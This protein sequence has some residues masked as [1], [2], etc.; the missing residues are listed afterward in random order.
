M[1]GADGEGIR[2]EGSGARGRAACVGEGKVASMACGSESAQAGGDAMVDSNAGGGDAGSGDAGSVGRAGVSGRGESGSDS[3]GV[4]G[5]ER[6]NTSIVVLGT[7]G[8]VVNG[9]L[10]GL[11]SGE[12]SNSLSSSL[13]RRSSASLRRFL[14][15]FAGGGRISAEEGSVGVGHGCVMASKDRSP[16]TGAASTGEGDGAGASH[17]V[18]AARSRRRQRR[19][20]FPAVVAVTAGTGRL[21]E[22][23]MAWHPVAWL[24]TKRALRP[25]AMQ[26]SYNSE[27]SAAVTAGGGPGQVFSTRAYT[28]P[29]A[30]LA[31]VGGPREV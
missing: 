14:V 12:R 22:T 30:M 3:G 20:R 26:R 7:G 28:S 27:N 17:A 31:H 5:V 25:L 1:D 10:A 23:V 9:G 11:D 2:F 29:L 21:Q 15:F 13:S 18:V 24:I 4:D 6:G 19:R 16:P 8:D